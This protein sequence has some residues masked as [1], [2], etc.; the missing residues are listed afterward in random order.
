MIQLTAT[1]HWLL[2]TDYFKMAT[3]IPFC[4][5]RPAPDKV[6]LVA[7]RAVDGYSSSDLREKLKSNPYSFLHVINPDFNDGKRTRPGSPE[8]LKKVKARYMQFQE[9]E[10]FVRDPHPCYYI[11]RQQ[12]LGHV[13]TGL[14]ACGSIDDYFD[15]LIKIHEQTLTEREEKLKQYL[16]VCD[17][18]AE[19][20]LFSY[21]NDAVID[22]L[23]EEITDG[24]PAYDFTTTDKVRHTLWVVDDRSTVSVLETQ[25]KSIPA[26]YIA[27]GHHRSASSALLGK[28][29]RSLNPN[30]KGTEPYN[31]YLGVFFPETQLKIYDF[32]RVVHDLHELKEEEFLKKIGEKFILEEKG[33]IVY[34]PACKHNFSMYLGGKWYSL[35]PKPGIVHD[36]EPVGSLDA[37]IL[38]QHILS[39]ILGI[40]DLKTDKRV[41]FVSGIKGMEELQ[42]QV[43]HWKSKVAFGLFPVSMD[44]LKRIADTGNIMPPKTTWVEPKMRS[45]L[46]IYSLSE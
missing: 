28:S 21:P 6:H 24:R 33:S 9:E 27:D 34:K 43:D 35:T 32:N 23:T 10:V 41:G 26:I 36:K 29:R 39:P 22:K 5:I 46:V 40:H 3:I 8:R 19:P 17:F 45:G 14:I 31:F 18:N 38:T 42:N 16:E 37:F 13:Y 30:H 4:G 7:S 25:F 44:Q 11:Y 12:K 2:T 15:G 20:V 1:G